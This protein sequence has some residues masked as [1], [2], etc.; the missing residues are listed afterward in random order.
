MQLPGVPAANAFLTRR[1]LGHLGDR[2]VTFGHAL[3]SRGII[4]SP[5]ATDGHLHSP[6]HLCWTYLTTWSTCNGVVAFPVR[7]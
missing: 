1:V 7:R 6:P 2:E 3:A 5:S 4:L